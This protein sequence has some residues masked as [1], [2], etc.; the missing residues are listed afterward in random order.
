ME[1]YKKD[2]FVIMAIKNPETEF[3]W[4]EVFVPAIESVGC[5]PRRI[6]KDEDGSSLSDLIFHFIKNSAILIADL[7]LSRPNCYL[8]VGYAMG[9]RSS[10]E[11]ILCCREDHNADS[12]NY[13]PGSNKIHF[14]IRQHNIIWWEE[15]HLE[16]FKE[17]LIT[18]LN[19]R[20]DLID[21]REPVPT[22]PQ[23]D[24]MSPGEIK[25]SPEIDHKIELTRRYLEAW[26]KK[27]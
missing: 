15:N 14:D 18:K 5:K 1:P 10:L 3:L 2:C 24:I 16:S 26:I 11:I 25:A 20:R 19:H 13:R 23:S 6:D 22:E 8:E 17:D 9:V 27:V 4:H 12:E 21:K 7:T